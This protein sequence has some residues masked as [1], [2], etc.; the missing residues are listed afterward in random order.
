MTGQDFGED[1][2]WGSAVSAYQ[3]EGASNQD[4]RGASIWDDFC[5]RK[6]KIKDNSHGDDAADFYHRYEEDLDLL[7][8][9]GFQHFRFSISWSRIMPT[10][11]GEVNQQ[12]VDYYHRLIDSCLERGITPWVTLYHWDLPSALQRRGGWR[13]RQV[14]EW[15]KA[16]VEI[17][18]KAYA[19]KVKNWIIL[20]EGIVFSG[21]GYFMGIH[22]PGKR[23]MKNFLPVV[24]HA[25]LA[26][27]AVF[28][29]MKGIDSNL[30]IGTSLSMTMVAPFTQ[31]KK[32]IRAANRVDTLLNRLFI[33]PHLGIGYPIKDLPFL[34]RLKKYIKPG[35]EEFLKVEFDFIGV[36]NYTR[37]VIRHFAFMP[38]IFA[39]PVSPS[40]RKVPESAMGM[41]VFYPSLGV[42]IKKISA[43]PQLKQTPIIITECGQAFEDEL[44]NGEVQD[45]DRITYYEKVIQELVHL[46]GTLNIRGL[47]VW[48]LT[49]NFEW[50]EGYRTR[51]GLVYT[52]FKTQMRYVKTSYHWFK[53]FL[54]Q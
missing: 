34:A 16:Y 8:D 26:Q 22:A 30:N 12:G 21:A 52:D 1:F 48:T 47:F 29:L 49:D 33:E 7:K 18:V 14:I 13:N 28:K 24:H 44:I 35:D 4:G 37:E 25:L 20:N 50:A 38:Y 41:E 42:C 53:R 43:Y 6:G 31:S 19:P 23:G 45:P 54:K 11:E 3:N 32:D 46:K 36:Q 10:G 2:V 39:R 27:A 17:V 51:F 5:K 9:A 15:F 40:K